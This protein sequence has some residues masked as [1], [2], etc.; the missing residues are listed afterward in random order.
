MASHMPWNISEQE[1]HGS[2]LPVTVSHGVLM[3]QISAM[4]FYLAY[5]LHSPSLSSRLAGLDVT[6]NKHMPSHTLHH[7]SRMSPAIFGREPNVRL[8]NWKG[9]MICVQCYA[10]GLTQLRLTV[11]EMSSA[12]GSM[13]SHPTLKIAV[14]YTT[15]TFQ[16][17][18]LMNPRFQPLPHSMPKPQPF[19]LME[20]TPHLT[21]KKMVLC[22]LPSHG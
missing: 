21:R 7:G 11:L 17:W 22:T 15:R 19:V 12:S 1:P 14:S 20:P 16:P 18:N 4:L 13:T 9:A 6:R 5:H 3:L 8:L 2:L 10:V